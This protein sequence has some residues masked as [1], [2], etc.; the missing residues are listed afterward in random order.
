MSQL[1]NQ[2][3]YRSIDGN[4]YPSSHPSIRPSI[5]PSSHSSIHSSLRPCPS[6][7]KIVDSCIFHK[8]NSIFS[9]QHGMNHCL[10][11]QE[12]IALQCS[13]AYVSMLCAQDTHSLSLSLPLSLSL[14]IYVFTYM[15]MS[16]RTS[17]YMYLYYYIY[18]HTHTHIYIY[19]LSHCR[20]HLYAHRHTRHAN[21]CE[22]AGQ[23]FG[24]PGAWGP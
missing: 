24:E 23:L 11:F 16:V 2:A 8:Q 21:A 20:H 1:I 7:H 4:M 14:C 19:M 15:F 13:I 5:P 17:I 12:Y 10:S 9:L 18:I 3:V 6:T 22:H